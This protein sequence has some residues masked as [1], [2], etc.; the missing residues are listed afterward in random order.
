MRRT[1]RLSRPAEAPPR[2]NHSGDDAAA[3]EHTLKRA[4]HDLGNLPEIAFAK[5]AADLIEPG[6]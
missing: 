2:D 5:Q 1:S 3:E 4:R 6:V